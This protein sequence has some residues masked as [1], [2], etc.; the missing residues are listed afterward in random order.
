MYS[1][2]DN[3][4]SVGGSDQLVDRRDENFTVNDFKTKDIQRRIMVSIENKS[5][6][7]LTLKKGNKFAEVNI[8]N[9]SEINVDQ[10]TSYVSELKLNEIA[11]G[12]LNNNEKNKLESILIDYNKSINA[13]PASKS[14]IPHKHKI[15]LTN[16][17]LAV[18]KTRAIPNSKK[19]QIYDQI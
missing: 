6:K 4:Y 1:I 13:T 12:D 8:L 2:G 9:D 10:K 16:E 5:G 3:M 15:N 11:T 17:I 14:K 7:N 19:Q 18:T